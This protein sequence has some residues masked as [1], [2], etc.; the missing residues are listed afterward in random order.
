MASLNRN[1]AIRMASDLIIRLHKRTCV[2]RFRE[3][4]GD[5]TRVAYARVLVSAL[6]AYAVLLRDTEIDA[7]E[8]RL[9][10][11][12]SERGSTR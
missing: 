8:S 2:E 9:T 4:D 1:S 12:E 6:Q 5:R 7:L 11:L 3:Q 10:A